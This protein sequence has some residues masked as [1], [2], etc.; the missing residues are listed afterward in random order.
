MADCW[1][2]FRTL[3][4]RRLLTKY[5]PQFYRYAEAFFEATG[6]EPELVVCVIAYAKTGEYEATRPGAD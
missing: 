6:K 4:Q 3:V 1:D 5:E 2:D